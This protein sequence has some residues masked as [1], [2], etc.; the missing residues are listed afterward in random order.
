MN[1]K[2]KEEVRGSFEFLKNWGDAL[3]LWT[4]RWTPMLWSSSSF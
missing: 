4:Q 1:E 3:T 2:K